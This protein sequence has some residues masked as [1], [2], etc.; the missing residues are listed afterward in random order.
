[1]A[2][3]FWV[4]GTGTWSAVGSSTGNHWATTT[5]GVG[6]DA[7][8]P[9][10]GDN[11]TFDASSGGGTV[12]PDGTIAGI[13]FGTLAA[14]SF[15]SGTLA[16]NTNNPSVSFQG[17]NFSGSVTRTIDV[18]SGTW[19]FTSGGTVWDSST[20][21]GLTGTFQNAS[22]SFPSTAF[23]Q[24]IFNGGAKTYGAVTI[25]DQSSVVCYFIFGQSNTFASM[26][27][28][29][30]T[31]INA[32]NFQDQTITGALTITGTA[33]LPSSLTGTLNSSTRTTF[34]V[35]SASTLVWGGIGNIT[36]AGV[37]TLTATNAFDLGNNS[38]ITSITAPSGGGGGVVGVIGG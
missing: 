37:G 38:S 10:A 6:A 20:T 19:T 2:N 16:F 22:L 33:S 5:G 7:N 24:R 14:G 35:G 23:T 32:P 30:G 27:V 4:G 13:A 34:T 21:T 12:T 8:A 26:T 29:R 3:K 28:G 25:S 36:R 11:I 18:G 31:T 17:V 1:M 15:T 9:I